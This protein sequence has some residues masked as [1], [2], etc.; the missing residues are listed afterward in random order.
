MIEF[1]L[2]T[3]KMSVSN[4]W[5]SYKDSVSSA[6]NTKKDWLGK[7]KKC[8]HTDM[9]YFSFHREV[10]KAMG[11]VDKRRRLMILM[12]SFVEYLRGTGGTL[13][14]SSLGT[15]VNKKKLC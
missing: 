1:F 15:Y 13:V 5:S 7:N 2:N 9:E 6:L 11:L 14:N 4:T 8:S 10:C 12:L 3:P